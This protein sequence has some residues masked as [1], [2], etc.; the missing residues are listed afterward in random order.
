VPGIARRATTGY[1]LQIVCFAPLLGCQSE[2]GPNPLLPPSATRGA[3]ITFQVS[4][5]PSR[6]RRGVQPGSGAGAS[7]WYVYILRSIAS[8][9]QEYTGASADLKRRVAD[10]NAGKS[11]HTAK[12]RP[13]A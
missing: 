2:D 5:V 1:R 3:A 9:D 8:P 7:M 6:R 10:H 4:F 11:T 13:W 12:F